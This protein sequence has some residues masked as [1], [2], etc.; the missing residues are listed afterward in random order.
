MDARETQRPVWRSF[1]PRWVGNAAAH[2]RAGGL[3]VVTARAAF[4]LVAPGPEGELA[5]LAVWALL[6]LRAG[7]LEPVDAGEAEGLLRVRLTPGQR[8]QCLA[9]AERDA[10]LPGHTVGVDF[11][12]LDC[13]MCCRNNRVVLEDEDF[14]RWAAAEP[15]V[16]PGRVHT[17]RGVRT[18]AVLKNGDCQHLRGN[19]CDIYAQR[20]NNCRAFPMGSEGCLAAREEAGLAMF[21]L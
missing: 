19:R 10:A 11:A 20:P 17:R 13:A 16:S 2:A 3:A 18:L 15:A 12:C 7:D 21:T 1:D 4:A 6:D 14:A 8:A 9:W 5:E